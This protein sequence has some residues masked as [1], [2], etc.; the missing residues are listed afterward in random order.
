MRTIPNINIMIRKIDDILTPEFIQA[1]TGGIAYSIPETKLFT[2]PLKMSDLGILKSNKNLDI[3]LE[4]SQLLTETLCNKI[5]KQ[6]RRNAPGKEI[7]NDQKSNGNN[8][9][10]KRY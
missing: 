10:S 8:S 4:N 2:L 6:D 5:K 9:V 1:T 7:K 3:E